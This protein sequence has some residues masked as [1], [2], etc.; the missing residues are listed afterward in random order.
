MEQRQ[1]A[2]SHY[3]ALAKIPIASY[4]TFS[5]NVEPYDAPTLELIGNLEKASHYLRY[6]LFDRTLPPVIFSLNKS[7]HF[8]GY[9]KINAW[10]AKDNSNLPELNINPVNFLL[11]PIELASTIVHELCHH[12]QFF[13]GKPGGRGY[14]NLEF[15]DIMFRCGLQ[16][17]DTG[18]PGGNTLGRKMSHYIIPGGRFE[19]AFKEMP[20]DLLVAFKPL[21]D[22]VKVLN[23]KL[24]DNKKSVEQ[25]KLKTK[26]S[27][28]GCGLTVW[29]KPELFINCGNCKQRLM[30]IDDFGK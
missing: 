18:K 9:Y 10:L 29:G 13:H 21:S 16:C 30:I 3:N 27:C 14:H 24:Q 23:P 17:S 4:D 11:P 19:Q 6:R 1:H 26:Y 2:K 15:A 7:A 20:N 22:E 25:K 5:A 12:F 8:L 28:L